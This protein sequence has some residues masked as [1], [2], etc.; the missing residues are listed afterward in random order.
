[1]KWLSATGNGILPPVCS[2]PKTVCARSF[3]RGFQLSFKKKR[4]GTLRSRRY[5]YT[6]AAFAALAGNAML[7]GLLHTHCCPD[8]VKLAV[9]RCA[10]DDNMS[11]KNSTH[12]SDASNLT[13][14]RPLRYNIASFVGLRLQCLLCC[15]LIFI[16]LP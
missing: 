8:Q 10:F 6:I 2:S 11:A 3:Q 1:M 14:E 12:A 16:V 7:K 13:F 4:P 9:W 15:C 5:S